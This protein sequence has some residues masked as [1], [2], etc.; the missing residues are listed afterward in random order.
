MIGQE[1]NTWIM[2]PSHAQPTNPGLGSNI[3]LRSLLF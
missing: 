3:L 1:I 2:N